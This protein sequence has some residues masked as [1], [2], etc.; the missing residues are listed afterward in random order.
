MGAEQ[1]Q[2]QGR[3]GEGFKQQWINR[4]LRKES[5]KRNTSIKADNLNPIK[6]PLVF[7]SLIIKPTSNEYTFLKK[8]N[9]SIFKLTHMHGWG[10]A[11]AQLWQ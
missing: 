11:N 10:E 1:H 2:K 7:R 8:S 6:K 4:I 9:Y 5:T 3:G